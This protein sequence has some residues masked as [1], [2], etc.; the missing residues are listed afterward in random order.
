MLVAVLTLLGVLIGLPESIRRLGVFSEVPDIA[1][2]APD[3]L[4]LTLLTL[5]AIAMGASALIVMTRRDTGR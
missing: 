4:P 2:T 1:A 3:L 5:I